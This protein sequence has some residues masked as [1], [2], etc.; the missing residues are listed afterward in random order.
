VRT[1]AVTEAVLNSSSNSNSSGGSSDGS[2]CHA[3]EY[4]DTD[5]PV[6]VEKLWREARCGSGIR[7]L[8]YNCC[9]AAPILAGS[10]AMSSKWLCILSVTLLASHTRGS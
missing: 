6:V 1:A 8:Y 5:L 2:S 4:A 3:S 9:L 10:E 7:Q